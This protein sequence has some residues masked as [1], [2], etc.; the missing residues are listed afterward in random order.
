MVLQ[1]VLQSFRA[2]PVPYQ[3]ILLLLQCDKYLVVSQSGVLGLRQYLYTYIN[4]AQIWYAVS[5]LE[6]QQC[7]IYVLLHCLLH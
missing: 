4:D 3:I 1:W 6:L 2:A 7:C 5:M